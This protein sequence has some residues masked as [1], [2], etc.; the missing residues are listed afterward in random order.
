[1]GTVP[2]LDPGRK[3]RESLLPS[4]VRDVGSED[5]GICVCLLSSDS[6][7]E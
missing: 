3:P 4:Q 2:E 5:L 6:N 1:M 7:L